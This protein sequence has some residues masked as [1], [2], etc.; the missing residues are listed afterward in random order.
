MLVSAGRAAATAP[1]SVTV[2]GDLQS[3][4]GCAG[5]WD[6][7]CSATHLSYDANSAVWKG[8]WTL[9]AGNY[10]YKVALNDSW[11][12]SYGLH[13]ARSGVRIA[14]AEAAG[15]LS[16]TCSVNFSAS[17]AQAVVP[18]CMKYDALNDQF[19]YNWKLGKAPGQQTITITVSSGGVTSKS[20]SITIVK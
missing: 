13:A 7:A 20:G 6:P 10:Q 12:E 19:V 8:T 18:T 14:D 9:P 4:R 5:D 3:E 17:G 2:A 15:L 11:N 16:P 1:T